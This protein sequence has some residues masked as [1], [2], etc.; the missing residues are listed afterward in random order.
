M[1]HTQVQQLLIDHI[2]L[3]TSSVE[4]KTSAGRGS[5]R[6][7]QLH[8]IKK[9]RELILELAVRGKLVP[10]DASDEPAAVL[11]QRIAA[12]RDRL[13]KEKL[14]KKPKV[15]PE[16]TEEEKPFELP[17]GWEWVR[18]GNIAAVGTG[19]TPSRSNPLYYDP[20]EF[21]WLTSGE[22]GKDYIDETAEKISSLAIKET[23]VSIYPPGTLIIAM[24]GQGKT[25][26]QITELRTH[27][28]TNQACAAIQLIEQELEHRTYIKLF[29]KKSYE[30]IRTEA[31]GG[32]Q[33]N[34][35]LG[36]INTTVIPLPPTQEQHRI[37]AKVDEL[38]ALC[39]QLEQ[40]TEQQLDAHQQLVTTL[41]DTLTQSKNAAELA[42]NWARLSQHFNTLF[43][44][45]ASIDLLKQTILQ[46]AVMGKLVPQDPTDEPASALLRRI[47]SEKEQLIKEKKIKKQKPLPAISDEEK[48]FGLP[49]G[50]E[51]CRFATYALEM[52][53]GPFGSM[54]NKREYVIGGTPLINPSH[55]VNGRIVEDEKVTVTTEK[56]DELS[57]YA[58]YEGDVVM[59]RRGE[60]GRCAIVTSREDNWL[61]GTGSFV[62]KFTT[63]VN[64]EFICTLFSTSSTRN[65]LG[66]ESVGATMTNLNHSILNKMPL[67]LPPLPEQHR[68][69]TKVNELF[70]LCDQLKQQLQQQQRTQLLLTDTLVQDALNR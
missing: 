69:V 34:L 6:K 5:N 18:I 48:P 37:V 67:M 24:Y 49:E 63:D 14:I 40:Q 64:R 21:F 57:S 47:A 25:R 11:L 30:E 9:L 52:A 35:N 53:T 36:K 32:A 62:L 4:H 28:G 16:I 41:L 13:V 38:M 1:S 68:I 61:C 23:N 55:M 27:S 10:Q 60:M 7:Q 54:I 29:F 33:P 46:L 66:G 31:A 8:G 59:A 17:V 19:A 3:W 56:A 45:D 20:A 22:T 65:Y 43:T 42:A 51:W 50:W 70:A 44:T 26:G 39:D 2:D 12:E 58:L 15:L